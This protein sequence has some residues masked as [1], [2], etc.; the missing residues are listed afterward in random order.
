[1]NTTH[2]SPFE[3]HIA[4]EIRK[5]Y[6]VDE[7]LFS[8]NGNIIFPNF[9]AVRELAHKINQKRNKENDVRGEI[10]AAQLNAMGL[11]DE[12]SHFIVRYYDEKENPGVI[13]RAYNYLANQ[14]G[15]E[16][17]DFTLQKFLEEFPPIDVYQ[18]KISIAKYFAKTTEGRANKHIALE[19][20]M[21]LFLSNFNP[22][23]NS[24]NELFNDANLKNSTAYSTIIEE[25]EKYF[26]SEKP[27]GPDK[28]FLFEA[29]KAPILSN[30]DS[31]EAQLGFI[32]EKW[33]IILSA[34]YFDKIVLSIEFSKEED[35]FIW[36]KQH[37]GI[38]GEKQVETFV[39]EYKKGKQKFSAEEQKRL[40]AQGVRHEDYI[41]A[42]PERFTADLDWMPNVVIIAKNTYVWLDQ[43]SKKYSR[44]I[45]RLD[46]IPDEELD[47]LAKWNFTGL[48]LIGVWERSAASKRIKQITGNLDAVSSAYSLYDYEIAYDLGG[49][50]AFQNLN[51]RAW[52]RGIRLAGDMVPNHIGLYSKWVIEHPEYF[53]QSDRPPYPN[54]RFTGEN[55]S[56][57]HD[58]EL[59]IEDGYWSRSDA[60]VVFQRIDKRTGD[61][62]YF[63]HGN[64]GTS[65]PWNDTAQ[66]NLL[67]ADVREAIIQN[68]F[69]VA[70]KFS[71]IRFDA[72]MTLAKKHY[73]RLW[74]PM[75]GTSGVPS[76]QDCGMSRTEFDSQFPNEFWR[77]VVD[78]FNAEMPNTL[79]LAE[80][81]WLMEGYFVRTLGMHRVYNSAFMHMLMKEE[82]QKYR[83]LIKNTLEFNPE[84]LKRYVNFMSN[85]DE[86]TAIAQFGAGDKYFGIALMMVTLPGLP[87]FAHGQIE[88]F[89]E[90]Y[91]MEY[92]RA[93]YDEKPNEYLVHR[94]ALE[95][96]PL[97]KKRY[98]FSQVHNFE[99]Y[100]FWDERG[101]VNENVFAYS[102]KVGNEKALV[103]FHNKFEET[104]GSIKYSAKK[105]VGNE[106][107]G[108]LK[109]KHIAE[110]FEI[111]NESNV[112][113]IYREHRTNNEFIRSGKDIWENGFTMFLRAFD[114]ALFLDF[115][116]EIDTT[117]E[118]A[119]LSEMLHGNGSS[120]IT[121]LLFDLRL[122]PLHDK[123]KSFFQ[124]QILTEFIAECKKNRSADV[125]S[126]HTAFLEIAGNINHII[127]SQMEWNFLNEA[128]RKLVIKIFELNTIAKK[129]ADAILFYDDKEYSLVL[130]VMKE[131]LHCVNEAG[132]QIGKNTIL[133]DL[134]L[135]SALI[136]VLQNFGRAREDA[137][138][139]IRLI[140]VLLHNGENFR[141]GNSTLAQKF[142]ILFEQF[143]AA[144]F[145]DLHQY[146]ST[147]YFNKERFERLSSWLLLDWFSEILIDE[148]KRSIESTF[149]T[150]TELY[151]SLALSAEQSQFQLEVFQEKI[152]ELNSVQKMKTK[153]I[154]IK[155][156]TKNKVKKSITKKRVSAK[157]GTKKNKK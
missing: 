85:P 97:M 149:I 141:S 100:D 155:R 88:G 43:L 154:V 64:D 79:L 4:K 67:R 74:Y 84:I 119:R 12:I 93:Y 142:E 73:Q 42:E 26:L 114:Y 7:S 46:Q 3:F 65:M 52:Q 122:K 104:R 130:F 146:N 96:F 44:E 111:K 70:R 127:G 32:K 112:F 6:S 25:L 153:K 137:D 14:L 136:E 147:W 113:Y 99:A 61:V 157:S 39:P 86:Q 20:M 72:A 13:Q 53:I 37:G 81:F 80:A 91:G 17:V 18:H 107:T 133:N 135:N 116:E 15:I 68:I 124:K 31:L 118:Y 129:N 8:F 134:R 90:K 16:K 23:N 49:E 40:M 34:K 38:W 151:N 75:P 11:L 62:K 56:T 92:Q 50:E 55:L 150:F 27:F 128:C 117:G 143:Q 139:H 36:Q 152:V 24:L 58:I 138:Y 57:N 51:Y 48:W 95:I 120:N 19:E 144:D 110:S 145:I 28:Q 148:P 98:L 108:N 156:G 109:T 30:P 87:M 115:R 5:K 1:M 33:G 60:A 102:N 54:Y 123:F 126:F 103:F 59:R 89:T 63:Y 132:K 41:Y 21:M 82:N 140:M 22:A 45:K 105:I 71:I 94:H 106:E 9:R 121:S 125:S 2:F 83:D 35:Q 47:Q 131:I 101:N 29:L 77:E 10:R 76:R 66:L 78:R 69:H